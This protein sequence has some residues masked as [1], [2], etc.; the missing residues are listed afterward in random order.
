MTS[1]TVVNCLL[2]I[3]TASWIWCGLPRC[4]KCSGSDLLGC[5]HIHKITHQW[6]KSHTNV[7]PLLIRNMKALGPSPQRLG[8]VF[9]SFCQSLPY[10]LLFLTWPYHR[11][12]RDCLCFLVSLFT[13]PPDQQAFTRQSS[14]TSPVLCA[15]DETWLCLYPGSQTNLGVLS[16][17]QCL[18]FV[19]FGLVFNPCPSLE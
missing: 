1:L 9:S 4:D 12:C 19:W 14:G 13:H 15:G 3:P 7:N 5:C 11:A 17:S 6:Y 8:E 18:C 16:V 2:E 10:F